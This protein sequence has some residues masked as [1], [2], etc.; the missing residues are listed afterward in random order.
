MENTNTATDP[1]VEPETEPN[2]SVTDGADDIQKP[3]ADFEAQ[4]A[5]WKAMSR[6]NEDAFKKASRN[7][8]ERE[9]QLAERDLTIA[10]MTAQKEHPQ[11][12]D[13]MFEAMCKE[14]TP[15][16]VA[17]WADKLAQFIDVK[18]EPAKSDVQ[19]GDESDAFAKAYPQTKAS[20]D[21]HNMSKVSPGKWVGAQESEADLRKRVR[22]EIEER[23]KKATGR[24]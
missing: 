8:A 2:G 19:D 20:I 7:L 24:Q 15:E 4:A 21:R 14:T 22:Q 9:A 1:V 3:D 10:R 16:G 23:R 17:E 5:H 18:N 6:K 11:L 12:T 13:E